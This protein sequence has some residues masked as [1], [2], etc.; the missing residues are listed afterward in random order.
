MHRQS[1]QCRVLCGTLSCANF[2]R[3]CSPERGSPL[4][5][6]DSTLPVGRDHVRHCSYH[7]RNGGLVVPDQLCAIPSAMRAVRWLLHL[8]VLPPIE[9]SC[10]KL[11][12]R[13]HE[14]QKNQPLWEALAARGV[15]GRSGRTLQPGSLQLGNRL[16]VL[17]PANWLGL[18]SF[19]VTTPDAVVDMY[20][21]CILAYY[22]CSSLDAAR[23]QSRER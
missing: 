21:W 8:L 7:C 9:I 15:P 4:T 13:S 14:S 6:A 22:S 3:T 1:C 16:A 12:P 11:L 17:A 18:S 5:C 19:F 20:R 10:S 2:R 23:L